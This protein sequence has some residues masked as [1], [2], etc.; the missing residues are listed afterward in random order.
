MANFEIVIAFVQVTA[1]KYIYFWKIKPSLH[2]NLKL[3]IINLEL[4]L[5]THQKLSEKNKYS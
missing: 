3:N 1:S 5:D 2:F 4:L